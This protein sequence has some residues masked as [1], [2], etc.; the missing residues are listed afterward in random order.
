M[1]LLQGYLIGR[2]CRWKG[3]ESISFCR[4]GLKQVSVPG[5]LGHHRQVW[6]MYKSY[7]G[8]TR[9]LV[10][11]AGG[12]KQLKGTEKPWETLPVA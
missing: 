3:D 5:S 12:I 9:P 7:Q 4:L 10:V 6:T 1:S 8:R 11:T 2:P